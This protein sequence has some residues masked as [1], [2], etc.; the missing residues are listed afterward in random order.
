[1]KANFFW[2][3][4]LL[5]I[6]NITLAANDCRHRGSLAQE[7]CDEDYNL[8]ADLPKDPQFHLSPSPLIISIPPTENKI[9]YRES[10]EDFFQY[11]E[12]CLDRPIIFYPMHSNEAEVEA[13]R[14]GKIHLASFSSGTTIA[15]VNRAGAVPFAV[16]G[17]HEGARFVQLLVLVRHDSP[18][19]TLTDL[20]NSRVAHVNQ[21]SSTGHLMPLALFPN[22]GIIPGI[23]YQIIFTNKHHRSISGVKSGDYH[24]ATITS[25]IF[26]R[27]IER[28][29]IQ[30]S[31]FRIIYKAGPVPSAAFSYKHDLAPKLQEEIRTC[32]FNF[33]FSDSMKKIHLNAD[34]FMPIDY[35][36]HWKTSREILEDQIQ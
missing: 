27:M 26:E 22:E 24:A 5:N 31:D 8:V 17:D 6:V 33:R 34:R 35:K 10:F 29:E 3:L 23:D 28:Q 36:N 4:F 9:S 25:E 2:G 7:Y 18:Y 21:H 19:Q 32:F 16:K 15:A 20:K 14:T 12:S 11:L 13:M 30:A 1:M